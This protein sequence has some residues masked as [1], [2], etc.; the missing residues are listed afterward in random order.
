LDIL[1][2]IPLARSNAVEDEKLSIWR[3][4]IHFGAEADQPKVAFHDYGPINSAK[5]A[6]PIQRIKQPTRRTRGR[7]EARWPEQQSHLDRRH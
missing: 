1:A 6:N 2:V 4:F 7:S 3:Q 5:F